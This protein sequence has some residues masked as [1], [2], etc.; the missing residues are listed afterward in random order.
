M[1][2]I[3]Q[4]NYGFW[5]FHTSNNHLKAKSSLSSH[6][7]VKASLV[8]YKLINTNSSSPFCKWFEDES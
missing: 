2:G 3:D 1:V 4:E 5:I 8:S 6:V 7:T